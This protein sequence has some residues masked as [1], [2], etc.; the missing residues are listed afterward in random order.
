MD[1]R[2]KRLPSIPIV[3]PRLNLEQGRRHQVIAELGNHIGRTTP[4]LE[5]VE[6]LPQSDLS[7][8]T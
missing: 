3:R 5:H 1:L 7:M 4:G 8:Q 6:K 2:L